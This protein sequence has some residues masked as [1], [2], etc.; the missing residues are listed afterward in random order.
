VAVVSIP[1]D[2]ALAVEDALVDNDADGTPDTLDGNND[3]DGD[4]PLFFQ[5]VSPN[6]G[7]T[8]IVLDSVDVDSSR[9]LSLVTPGSNQVEAGGTAAFGHTL[10]NNGNVTEVVE[11]EATNS[12]AAWTSTVS[13]DTDGDGVADTELGN[14]VP[15]TIT[16][17]QPDGTSVTIEVTDF[18]ADGVPE[19]TLEPGEI[20]PLD[21]TVF[22]PANAA[23]GESD[24][25]TISATNT[26]TTTGA[27]TVSV[28][29]VTTVINGRVE[30]GQCAVWQVVAENQGTSPA[31]NVTITDAVPAYS[32]YETGSL[33]YC[34][35]NA[36]ALAP[37]TDAAGDDA[38]DIAGSNIVFYVGT[39]ANPA[40]SEGGEL[41]AGEQATAQ[42]SVRVQ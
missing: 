26:D 36:C 24:V 41:V 29:D 32:A 5:I 27:P 18:D 12:Q 8:D 6:T 42:F 4:Y 39:G 34:L 31:T 9:Q 15:G 28:T 1:A 13:I 20:V 25:L 14:L 40:A 2:F 35:S 21:A 16:V 11:I 22:A 10:T 3:G 30:P 19:L 17:Q 37:V 33:Q 38:G 7:A 23:P